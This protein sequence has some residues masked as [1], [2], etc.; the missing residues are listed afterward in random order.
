MFFLLLLLLF[1][2]YYYYTLYQTLETAPGLSLTNQGHLFPDWIVI[3]S[4]VEK[5]R[6]GG[7]RE[8]GS[9][10]GGSREGGSIEGGREG[11]GREV[12]VFG[13]LKILLTALFRS[14]Y[15]SN[16][17]PPPLEKVSDRDA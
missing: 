16:P 4:V 10:E 6:E 2:Y 11:G 1:L 12:S 9:R 14:L 8:G 5:H 17:P 7:S 15:N 3:I 13:L